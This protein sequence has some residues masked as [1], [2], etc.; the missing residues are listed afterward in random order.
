MK[1]SSWA[2]L[3][4]WAVAVPSIVFCIG[5]CASTAAALWLHEEIDAQARADFARNAER[6]RG[7]V[8][9]RMMEPINGL[10][11]AS[12][13]YA[14]TGKLDRSM[15]RAYVESLDLHGAF[16]GVLGFGFVKRMRTDDQ[17]SFIAAERAD[18]APGFDIHRIGAAAGG[19]GV[20]DGTHYVLRFI[21]PPGANAGTLGLDLAS[22]PR[23]RAAIEQ[24][25]DS[26]EPSLSAALTLTQRGGQDA[27]LMWFK[28]VY[29]VGQD[30]ATPAQRRNALHGV[31]VAPMVTREL[32]TGIVEAE[33][34]MVEIAL[35]D[36]AEANAG[37]R[38]LFASTPPPAGPDTKPRVARFDLAQPVSL[39]GR[40]LVLYVRS[41]PQL[42]ATIPAAP[43]WLLFGGGLF[44]S[45][46]MA[47]MLRQQASG[48][49][50]AEALAARMTGD[51]RRLAQVARHTSNAVS[52]TDPE[53]RIVWVNEGFTRI[54]GYTLDEARGHTRAELLD[55]GKNDPALLAQLLD[56]ARSAL[57]FRVELLHRAKDGNEYWIDYELQ[58]L[59]D[60]AGQVSG[61]MLIGTD[62]TERHAARARLEAALRENEALLK[63][64]DQHAIVSVTDTTGRIIEA[65]DAFCRISGYSRDELI[66]QD[67]HILRSGLQPPQFWTA[68]WMTVTAGQTWH[69]VVCNRAKDGRLY[70]VDSVIAPFMGADGQIEKL[71]SIRTDVTASRNAARDLGRERLRLDNILTGTNVGT[72]EWNVETGAL[73]VNERWAQIAGYTLAELGETT[74]E[75][76]NRLVHPHDLSRSS[77]ALEQHFDGIVD[78][79]ECE[80]RVKHRDGHWVWVLS[81]GKLFSRT[82]DGRPRWAA[83]TH[84]D[85]TER[86]RA[87]TALLDS[88]AVLD[89]TGRIAGVGGWQIDLDTFALNFTA[90]SY[91][92]HDLDPGE[93]MTMERAIGFYAPEA[94]PRMEEA[95]RRC[96]FHGEGFDLE[97]PLITARGR[98]IQVHV[99]GAAEVESGK[100]VRVLGAFQDVTERH[101]MEA[102]L[103]R[104]NEVLG[105]VLENLP[106]GLSV[107][108]ADLRV[109]ATNGEFRR[110][111]EL[112]ETMFSAAL[113]FEDI[114]RYNAARGEYG[115]DN[116]EQTVQTI[117]ERARGPVVPHQFERVR[118]NGVPIEVRG[119]PMP[120]GGFV[121]TYTD[122]SARRAM[123]SELRRNHEL[124]RSVLESLPC[125]LI[126][127][128]EQMNMV[129]SNQE[130]VRLLE[131][132]DVLMS[133][134]PVRYEDLVRFNAARG[135]YGPDVSADE[136]QSIIDRARGPTR[137]HQI[138]RTRPNGSHIEIRRGPMPGGGFVATY[139][140]ASARRRAEAEVKRAGELLRGSIDALDDAFALF[141]PD[142]RLVLC[143][144]RYRDLYPLCADLMVAGASFEHIVR[145]GAE[146]GQYA[147]AHGRVDAWVAERLA[148]H[149][150]ASSQL[151][152]R[153]GDGRILRVSERRMPDGHT[154]GYRVDITELVHATE[155]ALEASRSKSQF[156][157][158]MSHEIRTP[159]NAILGMLA[160]LRKTELSVRQADY[161]AKTEGAARSLLGLL[162]DILDFSKVEAGKMALDPQPFRIDQNAARPVGDPVG[163]RRRQAASRCCST[164]T[165]SV[166]PPPGR[167]RRCGCSRC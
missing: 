27:G 56:A 130:V 17:A 153:L 100:V 40:R 157:A 148:V 90:Q 115:S 83:G 2:G 78:R 131:L 39:G 97:L 65:N 125:G 129:V 156:V 137:V 61:S 21:Q 58:P 101:A 12:G 133:K 76:F 96:I 24:A 70:W 118:P 142:D 3:R 16:H 94:Q 145:T 121:T 95:V 138:E 143:N 63:T 18:G 38:R 109:V 150:Q 13:L 160:L 69:G 62:V 111:L 108:D 164:S 10:Q 68:M 98:R 159:M 34:R 73:S 126:V 33:H 72:W 152:Q 165:P 55:S 119:A 54:S 105:V 32:L 26:G 120:G 29:R 103:R 88:E 8:V 43:P 57:P 77:V 79:Y 127:F 50:R 30:P 110:L 112:P 141:D 45:L 46:M 31:L 19:Q 149:R 106:C 82:T 84:M 20:G 87:E 85:I 132:P 81:R 67:H 166:P 4:R 59:R 91:R 92:L 75:L 167:R 15:F 158:N 36:T 28:P 147:E 93:P 25:I 151:T 154:V 66:G 155:A 144:Q 136:V 114:I 22:E 6:V 52:I 42:E 113:G 9:A 5:L 80:L 161:A 71:V 47:A 86:K 48:R 124:L 162:N 104:N 163:E 11:G 102:E 14:A 44:A 7:E 51:L 116:V 128:D 1:K 123:E 41:A 53:H 122:I 35:D 140:D 37:Q 146:R 60:A 135:E 89:K 49:R 107:V 23:R 139:I 99:V 117:I 64:L 74:I 134:Q